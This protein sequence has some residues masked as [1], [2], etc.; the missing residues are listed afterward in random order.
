[1]PEKTQKQMT[2]ETHQAVL[3]IEGT[4]DKGLVGDVKE[5]KADVKSQN[6]RVTKLEGKQRLIYGL[7]I[8]AAGAGG[9]LGALISK[10]FEGSVG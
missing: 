10:L 3:G 7:I 2:Y 8:G 1:M 6:K 5:I 4:E 9:G